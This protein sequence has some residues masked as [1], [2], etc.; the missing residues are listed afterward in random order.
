MLV[1]EH[2]ESPRFLHITSSTTFKDNDREQILTIKETIECLSCDLNGTVI[3]DI[4]NDTID[5]SGAL[6]QS[7]ERPRMRPVSPEGGAD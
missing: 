6:T 4:E 1:C 5:V 2:C 7:P 3:L